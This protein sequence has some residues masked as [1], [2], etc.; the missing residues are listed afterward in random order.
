MKRAIL[1]LIAA[2]FAGSAHAGCLAEMTANAQAKVENYKAKYVAKIY[3]QDHYNT[4]IDTVAAL[5][6]LNGLLCMGEG[7]KDFTRTQLDQLVENI[8]SNRIK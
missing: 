3:S 6:E 4:M 2:A 8:N 5:V 7:R 1:V